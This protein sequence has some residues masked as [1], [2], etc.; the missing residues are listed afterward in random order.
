MKAIIVK[1]V[2]GSKRHPKFFLKHLDSDEVYFSNLFEDYQNKELKICEIDSD[3]FICSTVDYLFTDK[4]SG[5]DNCWRAKVVN[6]YKDRSD[7]DNPDFFVTYTYDENSSTL[8]LVF[9][10]YLNGW[11]R[12]LDIKKPFLFSLA[13]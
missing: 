4:D 2:G 1:I 5:V 8:L 11:V 12:F 7:K 6:I 3:V 9:E 10:D 13:P